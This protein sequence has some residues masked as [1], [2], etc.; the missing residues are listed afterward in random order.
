MVKI[1]EHMGDTD[2]WPEWAQKA[3][4]EGRLFKECLDRIKRLETQIGENDD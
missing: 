4:D 2:E 3:M 1:I